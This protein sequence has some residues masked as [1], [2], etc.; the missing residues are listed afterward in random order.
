VVEVDQV[1]DHSLL[2]QAHNQLELVELVAVALVEK[3]QVVALE[4]QEQ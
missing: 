1:V 4:Q 3:D 2:Y